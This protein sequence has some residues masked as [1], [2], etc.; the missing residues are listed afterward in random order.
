MPGRSRGKRTGGELQELEVAS[1]KGRRKAPV[2]RSRGARLDAE[3]K[4]SRNEN[5][6]LAQELQALNDS[7]ARAEAELSELQPPEQLLEE[8]QQSAAVTI[9]AQARGVA[10]R[11]AA[12]AVRKKQEEVGGDFH[13]KIE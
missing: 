12:E 9:Q 11:R 5:R 13:Q 8:S 3:L 10:G 1:T 2:R 6:R 4:R 7:L